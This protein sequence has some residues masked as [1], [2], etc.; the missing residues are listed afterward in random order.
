MTRPAAP[1]E[2]LAGR[3][4]ALGLRLRCSPV[5]GLALSVLVAGALAALGLVWLLAAGDGEGPA[6]E[7]PALPG[8]TVVSAS[9]SASASEVVVHVAGQVAAPGVHRLAAGSRVGDAVA[10]AGGALAGAEVGALNLARPLVDGEQIVVPL[11]GAP[12]PAAS[13]AENARRPDG[14]L[15]LNLAEA[16]DLDALPGVGPVLAERILQHRAEIGRF[17]SVDELRDV[18]GIGE[19]T[20]AELAGEVTV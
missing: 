15:D 5:E 3:G 17:A 20:F 6:A 9:P 14:L 18:K 19:A 7:S 11:P 8:L 4:R 13:P 12:V 16:E 2:G 1:V 10:S